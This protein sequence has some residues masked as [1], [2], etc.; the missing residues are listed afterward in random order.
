MLDSPRFGWDHLKEDLMLRL[1]EWFR[2]YGKKKEEYGRENEWKGCLLVWRGMGRKNCW[3]PV[4]FSPDLPKLHLLNWGENESEYE[5][6]HFWTKL[7]SSFCTK[8]CLFLPRSSLFT[9][10]PASL[11]YFLSFPLS[12][13]PNHVQEVIIIIIIIIIIIFICFFSH[14]FSLV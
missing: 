1:V 10:Y 12:S 9:H 2:E 14:Q 7:C 5:A 13:S 8:F 6:R 11:H 4:V 3:G